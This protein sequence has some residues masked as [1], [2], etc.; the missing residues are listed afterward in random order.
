[1][2]IFIGIYQLWNK[3]GAVKRINSQILHSII[4]LSIKYV[5]VV[6][7]RNNHNLDKTNYFD[8]N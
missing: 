6:I 2:Q 7:R 5:A 4:S 8:K 3:Y 1:M